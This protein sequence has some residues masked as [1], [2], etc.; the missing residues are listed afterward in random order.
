MVEIIKTA[1]V[2]PQKKRKTKRKIKRK[3]EE[4]QN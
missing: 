1:V 3:K 4:T 2:R